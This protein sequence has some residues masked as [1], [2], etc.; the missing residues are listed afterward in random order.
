MND[1]KR[2][3]Q[4]LGHVSRPANVS[5]RSRL[6]IWTSRLGLVSAGEAK[7]LGLVSVSAIDVSCPSLPWTVMGL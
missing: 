7:R 4:R 2:A 6:E 1:N 5:S 3:L